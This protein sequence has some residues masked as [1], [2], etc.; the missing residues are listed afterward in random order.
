VVECEMV[1]EPSGVVEWI[2]GTVLKF[3]AKV[4]PCG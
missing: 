1:D 2:S 4:L 3:N